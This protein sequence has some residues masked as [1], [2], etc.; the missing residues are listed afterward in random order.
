MSTIKQ[1]NRIAT[2]LAAAIMLVMP[3]T[4]GYYLLLGGFTDLNAP[5]VL[6]FLGGCLIAI[7]GSAILAWGVYKLADRS[8]PTK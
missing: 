1:G 2:A 6:L 7:G 8:A 5:P 4:V 3:T